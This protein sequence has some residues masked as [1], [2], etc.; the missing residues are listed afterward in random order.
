MVLWQK[1]IHFLR[2]GS[3]DGYHAVARPGARKDRRSVACG[4]AGASAGAERTVSTRTWRAASIRFGATRSPSAQ[5][6]FDHRRTGPGWPGLYLQRDLAGR[7]SPP[8]PPWCRWSAAARCSR[9]AS[10]S[11]RWPLGYLKSPI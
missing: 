10:S 11:R 7:R 4:F 8:L 1:G 3:G 5:G 6:S 9:A 2:S